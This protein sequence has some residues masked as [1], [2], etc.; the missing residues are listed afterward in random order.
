MEQ[1]V[2]LKTVPVKSGLKYVKMFLRKIY[3]GNVQGWF[4][5]STLFVVPVI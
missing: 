3:G 1:T 2:Q 5:P 4:M